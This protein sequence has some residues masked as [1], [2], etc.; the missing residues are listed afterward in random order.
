MPGGTE[1]ALLRFLERA[2][3]R[4]QDDRITHG[5]CVLRNAD[6]DLLSEAKRHV[7]VWCRLTSQPHRLLSRDRRAAWWLRSVIRAFG[8]DV[9]HARTTGTWCD[10]SLA[11]W[12]IGK[13]RLA[14][15]FHGLTDLAPTARPRRWLNG[16][17]ARHA[18]TTVTV[19]HESAERIARD[20]RV[21]PEQLHVI[22][23]GVDTERYRPPRDA[24]QRQA[25]RQQLG[26]SSDQI[27]V[28][29]VA[30]LHQIKGIDTLLAAWRRVMMAEPSARLLIVGKGPMR[31]YLDEF[32]RHLRCDSTVHSLGHCDDVPEILQA[33]DVFVLPSRY[34]GCSNGVLEAMATGLPVLA[35]DVGG[36]PELIRSN[37]TGWLVPP[38]DPGR[39]GETLLSILLDRTARQRVGLAARD[40]VERRFALNDWVDRWQHLYRQVACSRRSPATRREGIPCAE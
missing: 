1:I 9:L 25:C 3:S 16:W 12:A 34:E 26:I 40:D 18:D 22:H 27:L 11:R 7:P 33:A 39:L 19:S 10:A 5:L 32:G 4:Q 2:R 38:D 21:P 15:S 24:D 29:C 30:N 17:L 28:V 14:L 36:N 6:P 23:N 8:A 37:Y 35:S 31:H 20:W 13:T